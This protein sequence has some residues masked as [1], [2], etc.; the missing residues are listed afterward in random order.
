MKNKYKIEGSTLATTDLSATLFIDAPTS[1]IMITFNRKLLDMY[2]EDYIKEHFKMSEKDGWIR[3][4]EN[5]ET[6]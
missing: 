4:I 3:R 6:V 5:D 2:A 1:L